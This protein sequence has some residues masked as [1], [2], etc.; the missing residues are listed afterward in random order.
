MIIN[1]ILSTVLHKVA[2][3]ILEEAKH[4][5]GHMTIMMRQMQSIVASQLYIQKM[6]GEQKFT[7]KLC[8]WTKNFTD[9]SHRKI[10]NAAVIS[11]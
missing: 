5:G 8:I 7:L 11:I 6:I 2:N 4:Y 10:E 3:I 9:S 1:L